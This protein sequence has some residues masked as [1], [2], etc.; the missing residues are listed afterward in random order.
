MLLESS[1]FD[2]FHMSWSSP[3]AMLVTMILLLVNI[4]ASALTGFGLLLA[5]VPAFRV[6]IRSMRKRRRAI[7]RITDERVSMIQETLQTI[8]FVMCV[9]WE[10][11]LI[12]RT[13]AIRRK[14]LHS[15]QGLLMVP[16]GLFS[17]FLSIAVS[18][19]M[20]AFLR[21]GL[22]RDHLDPALISASFALFNSWRLPLSMLPR[23]IAAPVDGATSVKRIEKF[24]LAEEAK[25]ETQWDS[26]IEGA[27]VVHDAPF[28][29]EQDTEQQHDEKHTSMQQLSSDSPNKRTFTSDAKPFMIR[30]LDFT[31]V[32]VSSLL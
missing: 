6:A 20:M 27:I 14:E 5:M 4:K 16:N 19:S 15:I 32:V 1:G 21:Y 12:A 22:T 26:T 8:R 2:I 29:W 9:N 28:T 24:L 25:E 30:N 3:L 17:V 31:S 23:S 18:A 13:E 11:S 10:A 7:N